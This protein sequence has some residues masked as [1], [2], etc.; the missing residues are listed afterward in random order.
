M[1]R[2]CF[3]DVTV[4]FFLLATQILFLQEKNIV[5]RKK[6]LAARKKPF[7]HYISRKHLHG[8]RKYFCESSTEK[9]Q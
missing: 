4:V 9:I 5:P 3:L 2:K 7:C 6:I 8:I 1:P